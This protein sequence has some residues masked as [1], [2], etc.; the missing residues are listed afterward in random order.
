MKKLWCVLSFTILLSLTACSGQEEAVCN[1]FQPPIEG[2]QWGMTPEEVLEVMEL[3]EECIISDDGKTVSIQCEKIDVFGQSADASMTFDENY[4]IGLYR[5]KFFFDNP[6]RESLVE[7]LNRS[8]GAYC[9]VNDAGEPS[10]WESEKVE[11]LPEHI[12]DRYR[13]TLIEMPAQKELEGDFSQESQWNALKSQALVS[14]TLGG[15]MLS[16]QA[17][18]MAAYLTLYSED[19]AYEAF[20]DYLEE[21]GTAERQER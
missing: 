10:R 8:Y 18:N 16:Y 12:Q 1:G 6:S 21:Q 19:E 15:D 20:L 13:Y 2:V 14:V 11:D 5:M 9:V 4:K 17:D 7:A 3:P